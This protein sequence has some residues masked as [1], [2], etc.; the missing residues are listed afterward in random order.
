MIHTVRGF[1]IVYKTELDVFSLNSLA[2]CMIQQMMAS[3][4]NTKI[5]SLEIME[6]NGFMATIWC[7][8]LTLTKPQAIP[9]E[10]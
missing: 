5:V 7:Y 9:D 4:A 8:K 10:Y 1:G 2:F 6:V 3:L